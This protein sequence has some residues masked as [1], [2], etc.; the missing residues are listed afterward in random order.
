MIPRAQKLLEMDRLAIKLQHPTLHF[1][2]QQSE[3]WLFRQ[4]SLKREQDGTAAPSDDAT[5]QRCLLCHT[6][7]PLERDNFHNRGEKGLLRSAAR[8]YFQAC[9]NLPLRKA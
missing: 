2:R 3:L 5:D 4:Q 9:S 6:R 1:A 8:A 7:K